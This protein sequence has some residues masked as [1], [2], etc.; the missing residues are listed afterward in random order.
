MICCP[1]CSTRVL[2]PLSHVGNYT[3]YEC[4]QCQLHFS[5]PMKS[6]SL[7]WYQQYQIYQVE[8]PRP[9]EIVHR[10]WRAKQ[11]FPMNLCSGGKLLDLGCGSGALLK[12]AEQHGY[13][14]TG[15]D[16]NPVRLRTA[17]EFYGLHD[18]RM[19]SVEEFLTTSS[20]QFDVVW[21]FSV[22]E[23]L[24]NPRQFACLLPRVIAPGG[25]LVC[26]VPNHQ[27]WP[28]LF[29]PFLD[30]P[31][32]HLTLWSEEAL[33]RCLSD[34]GM[35]VVYIAC[36]PLLADHIY[37]YATLRWPALKSWDLL[38]SIFRI[39]SVLLICLLARIFRFLR[40][41]AGKFILFAVAQRPIR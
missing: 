8:K 26:T 24:E 9:T 5:D 6:A 29:D 15:V 14:V 3:V 1:V 20:E 13:E 33:R 27:R 25:Y 17:R 37:I 30:T 2:V 4:P 38:G 19:T 34:A 35:N 12:L 40:P 21:L 32:H 11:F 36:S 10:D 22:L 16:F 28:Q 41:T 7:E 31:P 39:P 18:L 23:H